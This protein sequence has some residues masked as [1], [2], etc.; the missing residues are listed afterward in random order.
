MSKFYIYVFENKDDA[1]SF[2]FK[3]ANYRTQTA[4]V[5]LGLKFWPEYR[6]VVKQAIN[7]GS[8]NNL[9]FNVKTLDMAYS[10]IQPRKKK[11]L[12]EDSGKPGMSRAKSSAFYK[13]R[14]K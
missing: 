5:R 1:D 8:I 4:R 3:V 9:D 6:E 10:N 13:K 14:I 7:Y 11:K 12:K 2:G